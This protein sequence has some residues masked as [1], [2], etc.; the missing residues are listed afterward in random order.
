[1][2]RA[3]AR[4]ERKEDVDEVYDQSLEQDALRVIIE[5][6]YAAMLEAI[7]ELLLAR[8]PEVEAFRVDDA[9]TRRILDEAGRQIVRID[10]TTRKAVADMLQRGQ[11]LGLSAWELANG[12]PKDGYPGIEGLFKETWRNRA[13]TVAR[14]EL[15]NAQNRGSIDRYL[16]GG[17]VDRVRIIDGDD[18]EP[19]RSRN[20]K[21]V[22][23]AEAPG[24][25]HPNCTLGLVPILRGD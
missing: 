8:Y 21:V 24:L 3:P 13:Q 2:N 6:R 7:G 19:C 10:E 22:P 9:A 5:P 16:A 15:A 17:I 4:I 12:S 23:L 25:A 18:D 20:G 1:M 11:E 14:T